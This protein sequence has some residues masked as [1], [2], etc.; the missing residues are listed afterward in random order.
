M[1]RRV[2]RDPSA[3][4][5]LG[6]VLVSFCFNYARLLSSRLPFRRPTVAIALVEHMGDVLAAEPVARFVR[7][8]TPTARISWFVRRPYRKIVEN[9]PTIDRVVSVRCM[10]EWLLL[11]GSGVNATAWDLHISG[12]PC[13]RCGVSFHKSGLPGTITYGTY[14]DHGSLLTVNCL[15]AGLPPLSDGPVFR[16]D[17]AASATVDGLSL[18]P[19]FVVVHCKSNETSR[20]W[21]VEKWRELVGWMTGAPELGVPELDVVEIGTARHA[22]SQDGR[23]ARSLCGRLSIA[24]TAEVIR[25]ARLFIG[26][27]SGPAHL[28]N[29][30]GAPGVVLLGEYQSFKAYT[31]FSGG[32]GDGTRAELVRADGPA[33]NI[34]VAAVR[35]AVTSRLTPRG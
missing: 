23:R 28:A 20:D 10:T 8:G 14:Y 1:L 22:I 11:W 18:P 25:R 6:A 21:P 7:S 32:Y 3:A 13:P 5:H 15:A 30:V 4:R 27:D 29:A 12:R 35:A 17:A 33:A 19:H 34:A 31:P 24:E 9:Y 16:P 26:I 2:G